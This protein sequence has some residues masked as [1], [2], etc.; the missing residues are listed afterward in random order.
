MVTII[1][2][3]PD[4]LFRQA[5]SIAESEEISFDEFISLALSSQVSSWNVE[6]SFAKCAKKGDWEKA[7]EILGK[8][9][10]IEA[11]DF[12]RI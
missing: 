6:K 7:R 1:T 3:I 2:E 12:D 11:D 8:A 4:T 9:L 5:K 10:N